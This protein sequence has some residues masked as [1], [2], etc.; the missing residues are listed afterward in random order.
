MWRV[1]PVVAGVERGAEANPQGQPL[2][3]FTYEGFT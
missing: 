2:D 1:E 3:A